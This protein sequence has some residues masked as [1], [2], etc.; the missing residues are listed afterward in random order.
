MP[1]GLPLSSGSSG[2]CCL[3]ELMQLSGPQ[4]G[5]LFASKDWD[6][7]ERLLGRFVNIKGSSC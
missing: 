5:V 6:D 2:L 1:T 7:N 4:E 3:E